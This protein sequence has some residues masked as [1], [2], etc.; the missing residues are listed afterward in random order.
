MES[1]LS[2]SANYNGRSSTWLRV[3]KMGQRRYCPSCHLPQLLYFQKNGR[4]AIVTRSRNQTY[5]CL[6]CLFCLQVQRN[7]EKESLN[8]LDSQPQE[9]LCFCS[10]KSQYPILICVFVSVW[11][12]FHNPC[13]CTHTVIIN[14]DHQI[15][16]PRKGQWSN[17]SCK[18]GL[19]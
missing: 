5:S 1:T 6:L 19:S 8:I 14:A 12:S 3:L 18:Q 15:S 13:L 2:N 9:K 10:H 16:R 17:I 4:S 7:E 11:C